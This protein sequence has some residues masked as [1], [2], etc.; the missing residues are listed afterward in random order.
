MAQKGRV[1]SACRGFEQNAEKNTTNNAIYNKTGKAEYPAM[2]HI[3]IDAGFMQEVQHVCFDRHVRSCV[4]FV[5]VVYG[6]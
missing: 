5:P 6:K 2:L 3:G 4:L 1:V